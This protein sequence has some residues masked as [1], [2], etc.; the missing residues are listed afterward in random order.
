MHE[1]M[2][3]GEAMSQAWGPW[4]LGVAAIWILLL[5]AFSVLLLTGLALL[6]RWLWQQTSDGGASKAAVEILKVRWARGEISPQ[7]FAAMKHDLET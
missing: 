2:M 1:M 6:V 5:V 4:G 7:E 3:H